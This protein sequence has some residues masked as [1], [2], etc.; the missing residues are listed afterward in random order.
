MMPS[1]EQAGRQYTVGNHRHGV[2]TARPHRSTATNVPLFPL[3]RSAE[4]GP[5]AT[6]SHGC[7]CL[8]LARR[9][10]SSTIR[11]ATSMSFTFSV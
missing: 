3:D 9:T 6:R 11:W 5:V 10:A 8:A 2:R 1:P 4:V 7:V